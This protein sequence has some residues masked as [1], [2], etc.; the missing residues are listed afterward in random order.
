[1]FPR[2]PKHA[3]P[4]RRGAALLLSVLVLI[5][6]ITIVIQISIGTMT[7]ARV[8]RNTVGLTTME[9]AIESVLLQI[10]EDLLTDMDAGGGEMPAVASEDFGGGGEG[11]ADPSAA[12]PPPVVDSRM[13]EWAIPARTEINGIELRILIQDEDS[14][15]NLLNLLHVDPQVADEALQRVGR[16]LDLAR[17]GTEFDLSPSEG[18]QI[19]R[20]MKEH[21]SQRTRA[22]LPKGEQLSDDPENRDLGLPATVAEFAVL[23]DLDP[24][25]F[26]EFRDEREEVVHSLATFFTVHTSL[27]IGPLGT[28]AEEGSQVGGSTP[29]SGDPGT[30]GTPGGPQGGTQGGSQ[31]ITQGSAQGGAQGGLQG[32]AQSGGNQGGL[33]GG[34]QGAGSGSGTGASGGADF[35]GGGSNGWGVNINTA[36]AAVLRGLL[37]DRDVP[38]RFWDEVIEYRNLEKE[39]PPSTGDEE[40]ALQLIDEYGDELV[41]RQIFETLQD[42][43]K[44]RGWESL[45]SEQQQG[46]LQ[47]L[48]TQS[49]VFS[50]HVTARRSTSAQEGFGVL[51]A[52]DRRAEE[53]SGVHL[54]RTVRSVVWR[55]AGAEGNAIVP[56]LRWKVLDYV[57]FEVV[58]DPRQRR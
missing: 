10:H 19:A 44:V 8:A 24:G 55:T 5:V 13:D 14:K 12:A 7:D 25:L 58:D 48:T 38:R 1:M 2:H 29:G 47:L 45:T 35:S 30:T 42:L 21:M 26:R 39:K 23:R 27:R 20:A 16:I 11:G 17:E 15:Y 4:A 9:Q 49:Q 57:P 51:S 37:D 18:E 3:A 33:Q 40:E 50:I 53:E 36:P 6:V 43:T 31:G 46:L 52:E 22:R 41:E 28:G 54:S 32:G 56:L 34:N